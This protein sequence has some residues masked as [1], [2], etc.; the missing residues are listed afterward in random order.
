MFLLV[1]AVLFLSP[2]SV[3][4]VVERGSSVKVQVEAFEDLLGPDDVDVDLRRILKEARDERGRNIFETFGLND[5]IFLV[6][7]WSRWDKKQKSTSARDGWWEASLGQ[8]QE[9]MIVKVKIDLVESLLRPENFEVSLRYVLKHANYGAA[10]SSSSSTR[11]RSRI[12][13]WQ[14]EDDG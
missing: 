9:Q 8:S 6:A 11:Q 14:A 1:V 3:H 10:I 7:E 12:T 4:I 2:K 13:S 5:I